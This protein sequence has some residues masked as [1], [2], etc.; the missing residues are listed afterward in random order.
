MGICMKAGKLKHLPTSI[1]FDFLILPFYS[2]LT[3]SPWSQK[4]IRTGPQPCSSTSTDD[5]DYSGDSV[6][7]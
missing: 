3:Y 6:I 4:W 5:E 2:F 7:S 1:V